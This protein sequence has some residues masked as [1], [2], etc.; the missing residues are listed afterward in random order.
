M[1][2]T[3]NEWEIWTKNVILIYF[4]LVL[5]VSKQGRFVSKHV[6]KGLDSGHFLPNF[7]LIFLSYNLDRSVYMYEVT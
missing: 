2:I 6:D 7:F 5:F 3:R 1:L 4:F